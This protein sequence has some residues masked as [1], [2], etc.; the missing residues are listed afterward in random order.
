MDDDYYSY[1]G[2]PPRNPVVYG[3]LSLVCGTVGTGLA[4]YTDYFMIATIL[5]AVGMVVGGFSVS[6]AN[7]FPS[8]DRFQY[9]WFAVAG[10]MASVIAFMFGLVYWFGG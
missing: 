4:F 6:I 8:K 3:I 9:M 2:K 1:S 10:I 5:G 7:H